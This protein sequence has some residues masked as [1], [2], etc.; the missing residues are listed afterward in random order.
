MAVWDFNIGWVYKKK[1]RVPFSAKFHRCFKT[2]AEAVVN[3]PTSPFLKGR[4]FFLKMTIR[5]RR[6]KTVEFWCSGF[7]ALTERP[8]RGCTCGLF[9]DWIIYRENERHATCVPNVSVCATGRSPALTSKS[10]ALLQLRVAG[11]WSVSWAWSFSLRAGQAGADTFSKQE[12]SWPSV[13]AGVRCWGEST[14][15]WF[16]CFY[17]SPSGFPSSA[18]AAAWKSVFRVWFWIKNIEPYQRMAHV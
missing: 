1:P 11:N 6:R 15:R 4:T 10:G 17:G 5:S 8:W 13:V 7:K 12:L 3:N 9:H 14:R 18:W 16:P 2:R